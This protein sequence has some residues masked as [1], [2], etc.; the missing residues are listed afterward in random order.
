MKIKIFARKLENKFKKTSEDCKFH[1]QSADK[2]CYCD[3]SKDANNC[4]KNICPILN[5]P[6]EVEEV[7]EKA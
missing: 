2:K 4:S 5:N 6:S 1:T 7:Y 3:L